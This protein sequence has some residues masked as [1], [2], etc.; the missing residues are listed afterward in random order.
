MT[1]QI[2]PAY[3]ELAAG[4]PRNF[5]WSGGT[6]PYQARLTGEGQFSLEDNLVAGNYVAPFPQPQDVRKQVATITVTDSLG[7][8]VEA[9]IFI[10]TPLQLLGRIL[11]RE[12]GLDEGRV[13]L[14]D[15]KINAP[16]DSGL[17]IA[18]SAL[19][20]KCYSNRNYFNSET[21]NQEQGSSWATDVDIDIISRGPE[22][23]DRK[24]EV[25]MALA[26][27][28]S[29]QQQELN[30]FSIAQIPTSIRNLSEIDGAAIPYRFNFSVKLLYNVKKIQPAAF[31]DTFEDAEVL[32]DP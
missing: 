12:L 10:C 30:S 24:E 13:Y 5:Q 17:F 31:F 18:I 19:A 14:W 4:V 16:T 11:Q 25:V 29:V 22:A 6:P 23:R 28:Y 15:Q 2:A 32:T 7:A 26:S 27:Q 9:D 8:S 3:A 1:L 20:P 21:D